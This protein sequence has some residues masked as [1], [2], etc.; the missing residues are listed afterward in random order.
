M[1]SPN[2]ND[3]I[4]SEEPEPHMARRREILKAHPE[5]K[6][7]IGHCSWTKYIVLCLVSAH[8][9]TAYWLTVNYN[10]VSMLKY[11]L[12][13]YIIGATLTHALFLAIHEISHD[14]AF[15]S[16]M[17]NTFLGMLANLPIVFPYSVVFKAYH[18]DHHKD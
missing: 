4:W 2:Y 18:L 6:K 17:A 14:L 12:I 13:T 8:I 15:K 9:Y 11:F 5:V 7:L 16:H 3:E 1:P 10:E